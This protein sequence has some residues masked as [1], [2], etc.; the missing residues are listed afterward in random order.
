MIWALK[1]PACMAP[2]NAEAWARANVRVAPTASNVSPAR[3]HRR[4][5]NPKNS[6]TP[7]TKTN[8]IVTDNGTGNGSVPRSCNHL[9]ITV[10]R[11]PTPKYNPKR[12]LQ[13]I[14][15]IRRGGPSTT[16]VEQITVVDVP[17]PLT[18]PPRGLA[19][20][21]AA[22]VGGLCGHESVG[23]RVVPEWLV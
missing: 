2:T 8:T 6:T 21:V 12:S 20:V 23:R 15:V 14:W 18:I 13:P 7:A 10:A 9:R 19:V 11:P 17:H 3:T 1:Y 16:E 5:R 22:Q 4:I